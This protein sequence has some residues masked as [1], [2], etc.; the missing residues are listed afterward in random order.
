MPANHVLQTRL[1]HRRGWAPFDISLELALVPESSNCLIGPGGSGSAH[2]VVPHMRRSTRQY[3]L[4]RRPFS[5]GLLPAQLLPFPPGPRLRTP[6]TCSCRHFHVSARGSSFS[7]EIRA[8]ISSFLTMSYILLVNPN[9]LSSAGLCL[10]CIYLRL[11]S[12]EHRSGW[13][14]RGRASQARGRC[15]S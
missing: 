2:G 10:T 3:A 11:L 9:I 6:S 5:S 8:G 7:Q 4:A 13:E 1:A 15:A 12:W 14:W